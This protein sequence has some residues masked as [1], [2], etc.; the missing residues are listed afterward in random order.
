MQGTFNSL[1]EIWCFISELFKG[2]RVHQV[3]GLL[4]I[5]ILSLLLLFLQLRA[6]DGEKY[7]PENFFLYLSPV[8]L[9]TCSLFKNIKPSQQCSGQ[10]SS[11]LSWKNITFIQQLLCFSKSSVCI[12]HEKFGN[13]LTAEYFHHL[14]TLKF[15][16]KLPDFSERKYL[17]QRHTCYCQVSFVCFYTNG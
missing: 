8:C 16:I 9:H 6:K 11:K 5:I 17:C 3:T 13:A 10:S 1:G 15:H 7:F 12:K 4:M 2:H 14:V